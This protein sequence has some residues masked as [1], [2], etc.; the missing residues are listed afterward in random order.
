M[1]YSGLGKRVIS[2]VVLVIIL[3]ITGVMGGY[4]LLALTAFVGI[5]G[6]IELYKAVGIF[7]KKPEEKKNNLLAVVGITGTVIYFIVLSVAMFFLFSRYV[8]FVMSTFAS[9]DFSINSM[10]LYMEVNRLILSGYLGVALGF[11]IVMLILFMAVYV[12]TFPRFNVEQIAYAV[13][14]IVYVPVFITF[15][16]L[17]RSHE[18]GQFIFWLIFISSWVCD[19]FAYFVGCTIGKHK[20]APVLSPK[21]SIEGSIGGI[22]GSILVAFLFGYF[23]EFKLLGGNN[24]VVSYMIICGVGA[25]VS[26]I[27]DLCASAIKRNKDIKDYGNIIPGHGGI[28]DR[29]DSVLFVSPIIYLLALALF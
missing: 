6:L 15:I 21:K 1:K 27:G 10:T 7:E 14:G 22:V 18:N 28:L 26:Q 16:Y 12:F 11:I 4:P 19:T 29:F 20:L 3:L 24:N 5:V 13:L 17:L 9:G 2:G 23:V 8:D 25:V